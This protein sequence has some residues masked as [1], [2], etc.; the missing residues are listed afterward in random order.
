MA[1]EINRGSGESAVMKRKTS[2]FVRITKSVVLLIAGLFLLTGIVLG[3]IVYTSSQSMMK[4]ELKEVSTAYTLVVQKELE[5]LN[6]K[7][8]S[9]AQFATGLPGLL[10][11]QTNNATLDRMK[12][13]KGFVSIYGIDKSGMTSTPGV[14]VNDRDYFKKAMSGEFYASTPFLKSDNTVGITLA[15]PAYRDNAIDGVVSVG[16]NFDY[17]SQ[18]VDFEIGKTGQAYIIDRTGTVVADQN[19]E[20]VKNFYNPVEEGKKDSKVKQQGEV[21]NTFLTGNYTASQYTTKDGVKKT[22]IASPITGTDGWLLVTTMNNTELNST[23]VVV[24]SALLLIVVVGLIIGVIA[25]MAMAKGISRPVT[26]INDRL[27]LLADGDLSTE[28]TTVTTG[29]EIQSLSEALG[30]TIV[31]LRMYISEIS[32]VTQSMANYNLDTR[33]KGKFKGEFL[34]IKESLNNILQL[35]NSSFHEISVASDQ[36]SSGSEHV[37]DGAQ[38]LSQGTTEQASAVE[39]LAATIN[40]ISTQVK[41]NA[42]NARN[43]SDKANSAGV[44]V[45]ES[46]EK[47]QELIVAMNEISNS[48]KQIGKVI[49][50]IEDIAFQTNILALNAAVEAARAGAAGKGFAVVADEVRSL[51]TKSSEAAKGTTSLIEGAIQAVSKGTAIADDAAK[52]LLSVVE[53]TKVVSEIVGKITSASGEQAQ[54]IAQV[55]LG[56]DQISSVVQT[57]SATAEES[58]AAS[59]QLSSQARMLKELVNRFQLK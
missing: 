44:E 15:V 21:I 27:M 39:E 42:Q 41:A 19:T 49:K 53:G 2:L 22:A 13:S 6:E 3:T 37:S 59:E 57:N 55:T 47:M 34:P 35:I 30:D 45:L 23:S 50:T 31:Q 38:A 25:A 54:S 52:S 4:G 43:A 26:R 16:V 32:I 7:V 48:S 33:V 46:N 8:N 11:S 1:N 28:V 29:D 24:L 56:V 5:A 40:E 58:A 51:A 10:S 20:L 12:G 9:I 14:A 18:F 17:F 36:V